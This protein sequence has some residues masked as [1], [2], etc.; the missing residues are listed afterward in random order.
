MKRG[1]GGL[2]LPD[3]Q[4]FREINEVG[5]TLVNLTTEIPGVAPMLD[6]EPPG[7]GRNPR[8]RADLDA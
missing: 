3:E 7:D 4:T 8:G 5:E 1:P 2:F 6:V